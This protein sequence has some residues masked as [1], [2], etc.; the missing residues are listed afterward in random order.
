MACVIFITAAMPMNS[1]V[2][3]QQPRTTDI[4]CGMKSIRAFGVL[5]ENTPEV[6]RQNLQKAIDW[7]SPQGAALYVEPS[8]EPY[9]VSAG[10]ILK[11]NVSLIG[12]HGA[13]LNGS[14]HPTK[15]Q[16]VGSVFAITDA[17]QPFITVESCTQIK[18]IQFWYPEQTF[19]DP[20]KIIP[21]PATIQ[22]TKTVGTHAVFLSCLSFYG[23]YLAMDFA[24]PKAETGCALMTFEYCYG[25]PLSG[26]FIR[27]DHCYDIPRILHCHVNPCSRSHIGGCC[28]PDVIDAVIARKT[29]AYSIEHTDNAQLMDVFTFGT[30]GGIMLGEATYG[31]LTNFNLDCVAVGIHKKGNRKLNRN[32]QIAQ[33]SIIANTGEPVQNIHPIIIE[34]QGH[35]SI[36]NVEAFAG[37]NGA[38]RTVPE[39]QSND[40]LLVRGNKKLT[41][42]MWGCRMRNYISD[43]PVTI[44]NPNAVI[45]AIACIDKSEKPFQVSIIPEPKYNPSANAQVVY[46]A[47]RGA[48]YDAPENTVASA[49]LA[50]KMNAD[51]VEVDIRLSKDRKIMVINDANTKRTTGEDYDVSDTNSDVLRKLDAGS[52]KGKKY[53]GEKIPFLEEL[54][55]TLPK[56][57]KLVIALKSRDNILPQMKQILKNSGK[58]S[59]MIFICSDKETIIKVKKAYPGNRCYWLCGNKEELLANIQSLAE[60]GIDGINLNYSIIDEQVMAL[61][62]K[63]GLE[64]AAYTV[65]D[66]EEAKLLIGL[67]VTK[68]TTNRPEWLKNE[69][70]NY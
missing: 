50:W 51:A 55:E 56:D 16:P 8:D 6:N 54:I 64:V 46:I 15:Q 52:H 36:S 70:K 10:I 4:S 32:W 24:A 1:K 12:V 39:N 14:P 34:G 66:P 60:A 7:A 18:G 49:E 5:P 62:Q 26:E 11:K 38:L 58:L 27:I 31:Q 23:E 21:Y 68:I 47:N 59:R 22:V 65:N 30:Y 35:T 40:F 3:Y 69:V 2:P 67:G 53:Q 19:D 42:S 41:V 43:K 25:F 61:S 20:A 29:F 13:M 28:T 9:Y 17:S 48:S 63:H 37:P 57:K 44:E 45:Q 33:G